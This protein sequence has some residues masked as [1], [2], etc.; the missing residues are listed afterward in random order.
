MEARTAFACAAAP[1]FACPAP[2]PAL[3]ATPPPQLRGLSLV[4]AN[5]TL[6]EVTPQAHPHLFSAAGERGCPSCLGAGLTDVAQGPVL[7]AGMRSAA[8]AREGDPCLSLPPLN[9]FRT[10]ALP[11]PHSLNLQA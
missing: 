6:L 4:L 9:T 3:L 2:L 7:P 10:S 5:G 8:S 11:R 1:C